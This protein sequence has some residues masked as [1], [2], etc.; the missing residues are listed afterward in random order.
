[1]PL[2]TGD[3]C[4]VLKEKPAGASTKSEFFDVDSTGVLISLFVESVSGALDINVYTFTKQGHRKLI[5]SFPTV[6]APTSELLIRKQIEVF[7]HVEVEV[8]TTDAACYEIRAK[9]TESGLASVSIVGAGDW[10]V[11]NVSVAASPML[12]IGAGLTARTGLLLRNTNFGT[13]DILQVAESAAKLTGGIYASV[14]PG[15]SIQPDLDAGNEVWG[16][17]STGNSIRIEIVEVGE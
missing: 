2:N 17:S 13:G 5:D 15:E 9:G 3:V 10:Q 16:Q 4:V 12:I 14:L 1:M 7:D 11:T 6:S 8:I